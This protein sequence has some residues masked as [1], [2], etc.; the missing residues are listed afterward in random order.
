MNCF[1]WE[2]VVNYTNTVMKNRFK[3]K[4]LVKAI[5]IYWICNEKIDFEIKSENG[6]RIL[7][8]NRLYMPYR[9]AYKLKSFLYHLKQDMIKSKIGEDKFMEMTPAQ[10]LKF[11]I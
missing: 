6:K 7:L 9:K 4:T 8:F 1:V 2:M 5:L 11:K 3:L 10:M